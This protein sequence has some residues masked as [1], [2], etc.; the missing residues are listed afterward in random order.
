[1]GILTTT[2]LQFIDRREEEGGVHSFAFKPLG[3]MKHIA[4]QHGLLTLPG[5]GTKPFTLA[6]APEDDEILIGTRV[7]SGSAFKQRLMALEPGASASLR[8]P[9]MNFTLAKAPTD[10]VLL[11]QGVGVTPFRSML[12]HIAAANL[13]HRTTLIHVG[14]GHA[15]RAETEKLATT[16]YFPEHRDGFREAVAE[17]LTTAPEARYYVSGGSD[18]VNDAVATLTTLGLSKKQIKKATFAGV[19]ADQTVTTN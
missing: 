1:M 4:G 16:T 17:A 5:A 14:N 15:Y 7:Q 3:Q 9:L 8:G 6:S 12:R 10:V 18:F 13:E 11:A 19:S 2:R